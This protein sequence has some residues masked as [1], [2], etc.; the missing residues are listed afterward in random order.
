V[1]ATEGTTKRQFSILVDPDHYQEL[2][3]LA[4]R[5]RTSIAQIV[6]EHIETGIERDRR[7]ERIAQ[8]AEVA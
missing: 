5:R 6:R 1:A 4:K 2:E 8:A 7:L 3:R